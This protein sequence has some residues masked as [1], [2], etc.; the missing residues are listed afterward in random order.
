M[1]QKKNLSISGLFIFNNRANDYREAGNI[2]WG[3]TMNYLGFSLLESRAYAHLFTLYEYQHLDQ[4][5]EQKAIY[6][7]YQYASEKRFS[8]R[9]SLIP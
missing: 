1:N 4:L 6:T 2:V 7:G 9:F 8:N 3:A 5:N